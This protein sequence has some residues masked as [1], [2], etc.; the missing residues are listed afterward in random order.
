MKAVFFVRT[1]SL[2]LLNPNITKLD[3]DDDDPPALVTNK[4]AKK[5]IVVL[6]HY[7][8]EVCNRTSKITVFDITGN[9]DITFSH[10]L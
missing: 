2:N 8:I 4:E 10:F 1:Q 6:Q 5:Y 9:T 3:D 7:F